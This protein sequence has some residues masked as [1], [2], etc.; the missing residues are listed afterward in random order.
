MFNYED[1]VRRGM[2]LLS[3]VTPDWRDHVNP[4]TLNMR[5]CDA[6]VLA[7]VFGDYSRGRERLGI[8]N[9]HDVIDFGFTVGNGYGFDETTERWFALQSAWDKA[10]A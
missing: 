3:A 1:N 2:V 9:R 8:D 7:Q 6:C 4:D 10:L 5:S